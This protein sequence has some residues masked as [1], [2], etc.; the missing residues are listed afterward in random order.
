MK[1]LIDSIQG[2]QSIKT[3]LGDLL[4]RNLLPQNLLFIGPC[5]IGKSQIALALAQIILCEKPSSY[6][7]FH[8][9]GSCGPCL[10]TSQKQS[11]SLC[12]I[13]PEKN[14]I[15]VEQARRIINF[16][17]F[18]ALGKA[19]IVIVEDAQCLNH[20]ASNALLK[21]LE[22]PPASESTVDNT[23][24]TYF[25]FTIN[26]RGSIL[27]T[28]NSR[29]QSMAFSTLSQ[30]D[31]KK[32]WQKED[33]PDWMLKS[34]QGRSDLLKQLLEN[35]YLREYALEI[36]KNLF[37]SKVSPAFLKIKEQKQ[38]TDRMEAL[39]I[40]T[41]I[42]QFLRDMLLLKLGSENLIHI[43][44]KPLFAQFADVPEQEL[45]DLSEYVLQMSKQIERYVDR[46]LLFEELVLKTSQHRL[47][48]NQN[49]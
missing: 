19:K 37:Q 29:F 30:E 21:T 31:L 44:L 47:E 24:K 42:G 15:G 49:T 33:V 46:T 41:Y 4:E 2:H 32:I 1:Y 5:G 43:D 7:N 14:I 25:I 45:L 38:S 12:Y 8:A 17:H 3:R 28:L 6:S 10:R 34:C 9:C 20:Q 48:I 36:F 39:W 11:E 23:S 18:Q 22:E 27:P 16:L 35:A 26:T 13:Q 40:T